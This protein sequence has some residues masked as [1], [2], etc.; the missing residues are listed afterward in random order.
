MRQD[1]RP[2]PVKNLF[3]HLEGWYVRRRLAPQAEH[4]GPN[5]MVLKP[6][7]VHLHGRDIRIGANAHIIAAADRPVALTTWQTPPAQG[8]IDIAD[9]CLICPGV[10]IDS[11]QRVSI[12]AGTMLAAGS[13]ITDADWHDLHDRTAIVGTHAPVVLQ[14]NVWIG[15]G[16]CVLKGVTVGS[17]SIVA[18][19]AVVANDVPPNT[20]VA[21]NPAR[22]V[23]SL[24]PQIPLRT[25][26]DLFRD[27]RALADEMAKLDRYVLGRNGWW[28]WLR[29]LLA[30]RRG[31]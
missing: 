14:D 8:H 6:W 11:A 10:R 13:Y 3:G 18:A 27:P 2:L 24:D 15:D 9:H 4:F 25:R 19:R 22:P 30:P 20:I 26:A 16:A 12:G 28:N 17:N 1:H 31:D 29:T 7:H 21:G 5:S 23:R